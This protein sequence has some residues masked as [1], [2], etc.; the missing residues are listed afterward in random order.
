LVEDY[1]KKREK[2]VVAVNIVKNTKFS[3]IGVDAKAG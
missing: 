3:N 2:K 1:A